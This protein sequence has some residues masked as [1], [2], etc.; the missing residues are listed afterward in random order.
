MWLNWHWTESTSALWGK[1]AHTHTCTHTHLH[2]Y[3]HAHSVE[4][5]ISWKDTTSRDGQKE[6]PGKKG[7]WGALESRNKGGWE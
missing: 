2:T 6:C 5:T 3:T 1:S 4:S 7:K